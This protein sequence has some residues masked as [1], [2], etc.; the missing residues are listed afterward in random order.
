MVRG[1]AS[2]HLG[3]VTGK[4]EQLGL[5]L[6]NACFWGALRA[7]R[8]GPSDAPSAAHGMRRLLA[9]PAV[10][11]AR[12]VRRDAARAIRSTRTGRRDAR[13]VE[14]QHVHDVGR[15]PPVGFEE[16]AQHGCLVDA[17]R[18]R[19]RSLELRRVRAGEAH[20]WRT[21]R[22]RAE[23][24]GSGDADSRVGFQNVLGAAKGVRDGTQH[25]GLH[26]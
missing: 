24:H 26:H 22:R 13:S 2:D 14:R 11:S 16:E 19:H 5:R 3:L 15:A 8:H 9:D 12:T 6:D 21:A 1:Q 4:Y 10:G 7:T 18:P 17:K 25:L 23:L 20:G